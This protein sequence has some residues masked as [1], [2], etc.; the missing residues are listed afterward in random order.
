M[1]DKNKALIL[2]LVQFAVQNGW[3]RS[4]Q[5]SDDLKV[6][7]AELQKPQTPEKK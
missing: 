5:Q 3:I 1:D 7:V 4:F 6:L 2:A